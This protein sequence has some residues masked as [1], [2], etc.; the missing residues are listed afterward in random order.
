MHPAIIVSQGSLLG[1]CQKGIAHLFSS[2]P[3]DSPRSLSKMEL[4][5]LSKSFL[6]WQIPFCCYQRV[7]IIHTVGICYNHV[8]L[9]VLK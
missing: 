4:S 5:P 6:K 8:P 1:M 2:L 9:L 7:F 3:R